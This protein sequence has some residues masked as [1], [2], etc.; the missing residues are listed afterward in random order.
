MK[1]RFQAYDTSGSHGLLKQAL[2]EGS[3]ATRQKLNSLTVG[4][5]Q[6]R[7]AS[8]SDT[9][10][11]LVVEN[12]PLEI[13]G[14]IAWE[15]YHPTKLV[16]Y[17]LD[18]SPNLVINYKEALKKWPSTPDRPWRII[19]G[20][21][22]Q[23][24]G[25]KVTHDNRRKNMCLV[26]NFLELGADVLESDATWFVPIVVRTGLIKK[27][28]G[29]WST[30]LKVFLRH[31]LLGPLSLRLAGVFVTLELDP[32]AA[33]LCHIQAKLQSCLTDGE[34][35]AKCLQ[36]N[37]HGSMRPDF[38]HSNV[39]KKDAGMLDAALGYVDIT[40]SELEKMR[41]WTSDQWLRNIDQVLEAR[42]QR[43]RGEIRAQSLKDVIK[44]AGFWP[45]ESGL[46]ADG[47]LRLQCDF[48]KLWSYDWMHTAFQ[49]GFMSNAMWLVSSNMNRI[50]HGS[51][52]AE[53][54]VQHFKACQ[55]PLSKS[56][57]GRQ[58]YRLFEPRMVEK[59]NKRHAVV[60]NA[61][62]QFTMYLMLKDWALLE[63]I[64]TPRLHPHV[65]VYIAA[66]DIIDIIRL[67]KHRR[68]STIDAKP[69]LLESI[70]KW[71]TLHKVQ[72]GTRFVKPKFFWMWLI[73]LRIAD[74]EWLFDM[75]YIE[76]QHKRVRPQAELMK[77]TTM[78]EASVLLR[79]LDA[80]I[81]AMKQSNIFGHG[82]CLVG[83]KV[84][85][86]GGW[87]ANKCTCGGAEL[88]CD[89]VV[90]RGELL[91]IVL[92]CVLHQDGRLM[93]KV[94]RMIATNRSAWRQTTLQEFW[95]ASSVHHPTCWRAHGDDS[96]VVIM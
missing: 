90:I 91:A 63:A 55:F 37:G 76:R 4:E 17:V 45:T 51:N 57:V 18:Q 58:L 60:C 22:E 84:Q 16:Q 68:L 79:V 93:L 2:P 20:C 50:K 7:Q 13:G 52:K 24:P 30:L 40:C 12:L 94:E 87:M 96:I 70:G 41:Q 9:S 15:F 80:Q 88:A 64:D 65:A 71:F 3:A 36:W 42:Q 75:F 56:R 25:S 26:F 66:C 92:A 21:D 95:L 67:V 8:I 78:L 23:T 6:L 1:R 83:R 62:Q 43:A 61:S 74:S 31:L 10:D 33:N 47:D 35:L 29:G 48:L 44:A 19:L 32:D 53:A 82:Y 77:N 39:F 85:I 59:Q 27:V 86:A 34:G 11:L 89:D 38:A 49:D 81:C 46:L 28:N 5:S 69:R 72:Y 14:T 73:A 54:V